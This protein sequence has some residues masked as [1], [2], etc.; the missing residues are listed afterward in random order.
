MINFFMPM[1]P[2]R[3][4]YQQKQI[5]W[6]NKTIY[7]P[8]GVREARAKLSGH[9]AKHRP[10]QPMEGPIRLTVKW[11]YRT[12]TKEPKYKDTRPD[13]DNIQKLLLDC[14][15]DLGFWKDDGQVAS[16]IVEKFWVRDLPGIYIKV[17]RL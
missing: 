17:E 10:E 8:A 6:K 12:K 7:E 2:P 4:T 1:L 14:M 5:N 3:T 15:T 11:L 9:L 16:M 13:I